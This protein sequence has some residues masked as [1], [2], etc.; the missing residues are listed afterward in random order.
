MDIWVK[1]LNR[2][3]TEIK[4]SL[5]IKCFQLSKKKWPPFSKGHFNAKKVIAPSQRVK[6]SPWNWL[7]LVLWKLTTLLIFL[8]S[9]WTN[10]A[11]QGG[12]HYLHLWPRK[13][14]V[15]GEPVQNWRRV[16]NRMDTQGLL[17][18]QGGHW[19]A[20]VWWPWSLQKEG[21]E[22]LRNDPSGP[23]TLEWRGST[24][25]HVNLLVGGQRG[26][27]HERRCGQENVLPWDLFV[28]HKGLTSRPC[29]SSVFHHRR[30]TVQDQL[31]GTCQLQP[32]RIEINL[33]KQQQPLGRSTSDIHTGG[34]SHYCS[35]RIS[36]ATW[37][38]STGA[39]AGEGT[40]VRP[41]LLLWTQHTHPGW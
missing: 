8:I 32:L 26:A 13:F 2:K 34:G 11:N 33:D 28:G 36:P 38:P 40:C 31:Y 1:F 7:C 6:N 27:A 37:V 23:R 41:P 17:G 25:D 16:P 5:K 24:K 10:D 30:L 4:I 20:R 19:G 22:I 9:P 29:V 14:W 12:G 18:C 3:I 35:W 21:V 39:E 15:R